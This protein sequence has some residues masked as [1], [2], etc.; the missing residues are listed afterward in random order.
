VIVIKAKSRLN[1]AKNTGR[2]GQPDVSAFRQNKDYA[3]DFVW[4]VTFERV[5]SRYKLETE[6]L[7]ARF[8]FKNEGHGETEI[9]FIVGRS[10]I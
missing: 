9:D 3:R 5:L 1:F 6:K 10:V 7:A 2:A 4:R 8:S